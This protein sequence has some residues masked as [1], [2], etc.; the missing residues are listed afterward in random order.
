[1]EELTRLQTLIR[2]YKQE[3]TRTGV[4]FADDE[5]GALPAKAFLEYLECA[6]E[7]IHV[8]KI[9]EEEYIA[10]GEKVYSSS[11]LIESVHQDRC[12]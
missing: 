1:M 7:A 11:A 4:R 6:P 12:L 3:H 10:L 2:N 8:K 9:S 5:P